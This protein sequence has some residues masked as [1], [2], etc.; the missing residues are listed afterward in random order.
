M[1]NG[2]RSAMAV[3]YLIAVVAITGIGVVALV[4]LEIFRG[5]VDRGLVAQVIAIILP[6]L[7]ALLT[8]LRGEVNGQKIQSV[9]QS[10][11][12]LK[13]LLRNNI[14]DNRDTVVE[15]VKTAISETALAGSKKPPLLPRRNL[16]G[17]DIP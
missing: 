9:E 4:M 16:P 8:L 17:D 14:L 13:E 11:Q 5:D 10:Q 6:T 7:A 12:Q 2:G 15:I 1:P 3:Y